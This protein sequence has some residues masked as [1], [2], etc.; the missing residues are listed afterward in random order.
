MPKEEA[1]KILEEGT[2]GV[3]AVSGDEGYPYTVPLSY[4]YDPEEETIIFHSSPK[5]HKIDAIRRDPK[6]SFCVIAQDQVVPAVYTTYF[7]SVTVFGEIRILE[8]E[9]EKR[10]AIEKLAEKYA[11]DDSME[12][13][14][15]IIAQGWKALCV[16]KMHIR[17]LT[18][19]KASELL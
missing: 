9:K 3:L 11:P 2:S 12:N 18:G 19:K 1:E 17:H 14:D 6:A 15:K 16:L 5:G 10:A 13:R 8:E 7:R 4:V